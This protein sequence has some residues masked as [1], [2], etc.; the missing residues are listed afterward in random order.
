M[1]ALRTLLAGIVDYAG[2]FPPAE[3][4]MP[5]AVAAYATYRTESAFAVMHGFLNVF[6]AAAIAAWARDMAPPDAGEDLVRQVLDETDPR[7]F[8][9]STTGVQWRHVHVSAD[10]LAAM[11]SDVAL[12]FGSCSFTDPITDLEQLGFTSALRSCQETTV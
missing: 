8:V 7:Q 3:L 10:E 4:S 5:D 2:L 6:V 11:R 1:H 12:S 9:C